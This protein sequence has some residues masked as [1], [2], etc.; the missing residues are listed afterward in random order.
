MSLRWGG[1]G[2]GLHPLAP[3]GLSRPPLSHPRREACA[4]GTHRRVRRDPRD[5]AR[6]PAAGLRSIGPVPL[7]GLRHSRRPG[8]ARQDSG[9][10]RHRRGQ[11]HQGCEERTVQD[12]GQDGHLDH[13]QLPWR[14]DLRGCRPERRG[15]EDLLRHG[16]EHDWRC[17]TREDC[18]RC[19]PQEGRE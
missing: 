1:D 18:Q 14:Q 5:D 13:P 2:V 6:C 8:P 17:R 4:D 11:L 10:L 7:H 15:A 12:H 9:G 19:H 16:G 3:G